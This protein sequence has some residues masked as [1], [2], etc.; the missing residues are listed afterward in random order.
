[1]E[2]NQENQYVNNQSTNYMNANMYDEP[3]KKKNAM[4]VWSLILGIASIV[5][6]SL[7]SLLGLIGGILSIVSLAKKKPKKG[8]SITALVLNIL[9]IILGIVVT[10]FTIMFFLLGGSAVLS[11]AQFVHAMNQ[12]GMTETIT[13]AVEK[14]DWSDIDSEDFT[15]EFTQ[16][17]VEAAVENMTESILEQIESD[18]GLEIT[19][20]EGDK[21]TIQGS[22]FSDFSISDEYGN[23]L[24]LDEVADEFQLDDETM[25]ELEDMGFDSKAITD[26]MFEVLDE[27]E[28]TLSE[29]D[30][31]EM[32]KLFFGE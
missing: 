11:T 9:G 18:G 2:N 17:M 20:S 4:A 30:K 16:I 19:T 26:M 13:D 6:C 15:D 3:V 32:R 22:S 29:E 25:K 10:I 23:T 12:S 14:V 31:E 7:G 5:C 24:S 8:M 28:D 21:I 1:M 27:Y